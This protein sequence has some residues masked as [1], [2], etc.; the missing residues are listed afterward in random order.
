MIGDGARLVK[1]MAGS[2]GSQAAR[3]RVL[4]KAIKRRNSCSSCPRK[5]GSLSASQSGRAAKDFP[6]QP[7][8]YKLQ[9]TSV[10]LFVAIPGGLGLAAIHRSSLPSRPAGG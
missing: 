3:Q 9:R 7:P 10:P 2:P 6:F 1:A 8:F 5:G 4:Q